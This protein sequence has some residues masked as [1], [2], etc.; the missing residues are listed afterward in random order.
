MLFYLLTSTDK[1]IRRDH[2]NALLEVYYDT[3]ARILTKLGSDPQKVFTFEDLQGELKRFGVF[4]F[5]A[6]PI[7]LG[8]LLITP[9]DAAN[10]SEVEVTGASKDPATT[11][12]FSERLNDIVDDLVAFGY[13]A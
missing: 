5:I 1:Q 10:L 11:K 7:T 12:V 3:F 6:T 2:W 8:V 4:A 9:E 13:I